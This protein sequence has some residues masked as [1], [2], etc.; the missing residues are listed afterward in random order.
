[1]TGLI[2]LG[3]EKTITSLEFLEVI[4]ILRKN[5]GQNKLRNNDFIERIKD[6]IEDLSGYETFVTEGGGTPQKYYNLNKDQLLLVGMRESKVVR[7]GVLAYLNKLKES[8]L[9]SYSESLRLLATSLEEQEKTALQLNQAKETIE[10]N[11][12][13]VVFADSV[14]GSENSILIRQFAKDVSDEDFKIGQNKLF[15]W[16][17]ANKYLMNNNEPYQNYIEMG[18]FEVITRSVGSGIETFTS[19]TTK[20]T[21]RGQVYFAKKLKSS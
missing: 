20:I 19:K 6:E 9:P 18:L 8:T 17:R 13:K 7:R 10:V 12:P 5:D 15:E 16:F 14:I 4:N 21:G 2:N 1:M 3:N 11:K